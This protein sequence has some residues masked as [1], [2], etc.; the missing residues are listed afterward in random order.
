MKRFSLL[1]FFIVSAINLLCQIDFFISELEISKIDV[2][3]NENVIFDESFFDGP[4]LHFECVL[5]NNS[6]EKTVIYP[7]ASRLQLSFYVEGNQYEIEVFA[8]TFQDNESL[9][10]NPGETLSFTFGVNFLLGT[11]ILDENKTDYSQD[12]I[13][14]LPTLGLKYIDYNISLQTC[15]IL[16]TKIIE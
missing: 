3:K 13:K 9:T 10:I 6:V 5:S 2:S 16:N 4:H 8:L 12:L 1:F 14:I 11:P 15:K 7:A